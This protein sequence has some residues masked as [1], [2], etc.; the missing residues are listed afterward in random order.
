MKK[1][2]ITGGSGFFG[3]NAARYFL[4]QG[5]SVVACSSDPAK[6][7]RHFAK[8]PFVELNILHQEGIVRTLTQHKPDVVI[9]AA[10]YSQPMMCEQNPKRAREMNVTA[11]SNVLNAS[12]ALGIP[13]VFLSSDLVYDGTKGNYSERDIARPIIEYG[14]L[15]LEAERMIAD[16][17]QFGKW[18]ILRSALMYANGMPWTNGFPQFAV[19]ALKRDQS[20]TL[21]L[22]QIRTPV[23]VEDIAVAIEKLV[24]SRVYGELFH[25]AGAEAMN[26]V[27]FVQR[28]CSMANIP[29]TNIRPTY[30]RDVPHYSTRVRDV[31]LDAEKLMK[32]VG[33]RSTPLEISFKRMLMEKR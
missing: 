25:V 15:K 33:W 16:Q 23:Y 4:R 31:S 7:E 22:D 1:I 14:R 13:F 11:T 21:F 6:Y 20:P 29:V 12:A 30:M 2:L 8:I 32:A 28:Y 17:R 5:Y 27:E 18:I 9:H 26:R 3:Y 10:A 24:Q 19:E